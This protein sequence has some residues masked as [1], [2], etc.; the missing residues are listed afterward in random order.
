MYRKNVWLVCIRIMVILGWGGGVNW[1]R[2][3]FWK[4]GDVLFFGLGGG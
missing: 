4:V 2:N 3:G 1:L